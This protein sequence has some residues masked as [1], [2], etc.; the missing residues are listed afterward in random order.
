MVDIGALVGP[1]GALVAVLLP[2]V[3][4]RL[5]WG[6]TQHRRLLSLT[7]PRLRGGRG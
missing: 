6:R 4:P 2:V 7:S 5:M 1:A 3:L